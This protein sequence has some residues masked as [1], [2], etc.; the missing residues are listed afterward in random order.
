MAEISEGAARILIPDWKGVQ[1]DTGTRVQGD[2]GAR[3]RGDKGVAGQGG[4]GAGKR[5]ARGPASSR[6]PVFYNPA[7]RMGRDMCVLA[8]G[9]M[10]LSRPLKVVDGLAGSGVRAIRLALETGLDF[11]RLVANDHHDGSFENIK[12][13]I[14]R[15]GLE[16]RVEPS[17]MDLCALLSPERFDYIDIDPFGSPVEFIPAAVRA[18]RHG[19]MLGITATD[20]GPLCGTNPSTC[21][22]RYGA[23]SMRSVYM[24]ETAA[25]IM[26]GF[27]IRQAASLDIGL[28]PLLT[29]SEDHFLRVYLRA[30]RSVK[31]AES[32]LSMMGYIDIDRQVLTMVE[33]SPVRGGTAGPLWL[34]P[35]FDR[36]F[37][38]GMAADLEDRLSSAALEPQR[39]APL[40]SPFQLS[41]QLGV[42]LEEAEMPAF[43]YELDEVARQER[44]NPAPLAPLIGALR[45]SGFRASRTHF[46]PT[47]FRT[48]APGPGLEAVFR[49][50]APHAGPRRTAP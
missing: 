22:R 18:I 25:R 41:R 7:M 14:R 3:A 24:H 44:T 42:M 31:T 4:G 27:C 32:G 49:S 5:V 21:L 2:T 28:Q 20:T 12:E 38:A 39:T 50:V 45:S 40:A 16:S 36:A 48:D 35:L 19:G 1:G 37:V 26:I 10:G 13:N 9:R 47:G 43:F 23:V 30:S 17:C 34:G 6:M 15:N 46:C 11:E 29:Q 33:G 8:V